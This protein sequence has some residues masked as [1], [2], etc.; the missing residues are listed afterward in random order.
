MCVS[1]AFAADQHTTGVLIVDKEHKPNEQR[2]PEDDHKVT[3]P[4][5][6]ELR[7]SE[8]FGRTDRYANVDDKD[9]DK[10]KKKPPR[11]EQS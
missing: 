7:S 8:T 11:G 3:P 2:F 9:A 5:G 1:T 10:T 6:D 4:H